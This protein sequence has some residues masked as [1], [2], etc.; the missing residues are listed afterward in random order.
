MAASLL[1]QAIRRCSERTCAVALRRSWSS[2]ATAP[3]VFTRFL[4]K[5]NHYFYDVENV[6]GWSSWLRTRVVGRKNK[7]AGQSEW[8][9][10]DSRGRFS[11]EFVSTPDT[12]IEE[13][14]LSGT[15]IN[16]E[17]LDNLVSQNKLHTL[18]LRGCH[19]VDD[20]F[21]ARLHVFGESLVEL[22]ISHC[23]RITVGGLA[24]LQNL[25]KL[26]RLDISG[27]S[28]L[29][30]PGLVRI[31]LEEMLPHCRVTGAEYEQGLI[32][33]NSQ[34]PMEDHNEASTHANT[35]HI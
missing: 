19:E 18:S 2:G 32:Q 15:L 14:D 29:H 1:S 21:L 28:Q 4:L 5:L 12:H 10:P 27:L 25:R 6:V 3:S 13:V 11:Y 9:R 26:E 33:P 22:N 34:Q 31:L 23:S 16:H 17:G 35:G 8:F 20:W 30:S 7:F 24:A